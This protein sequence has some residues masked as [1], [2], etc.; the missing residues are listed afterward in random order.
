MADQF[1]VA[2]ED[3][4][5]FFALVVESWCSLESTSSFFRGVHRRLIF[6]DLPC[7]LPRILKPDHNHTRTEAQQFTQIFQVI[8]LRIRIV[9]KEFLQHFD[10]VVCESGPIGSLS[11]TLTG[12]I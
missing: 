7:L 10:L 2:L 8:V 3:K 9:L 4:E 1:V 6:V 11:R 12:A 5:A